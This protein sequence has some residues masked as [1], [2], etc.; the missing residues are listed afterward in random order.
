MNWLDFVLI[1]IF[2]VTAIGGARSGLIKTVTSLVAVMAGIVLAVRFY[3]E[4]G[5]VVQH[6][7]SNQTAARFIAFVLILGAAVLAGVILSAILGHFVSLIGMG[8]VDKVGGVVASLLIAM[9]VFGGILSSLEAVS[10]DAGFHNAIRGSF[11][12]RFLVD[13]FVPV[14][15]SLSPFFSDPAGWLGNPR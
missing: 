11:V 8:W 10:G 13:R 9:V 14:L 5:Q 4:F 2:V 1:F 15:G 12:A 3:V 7:I 6:L